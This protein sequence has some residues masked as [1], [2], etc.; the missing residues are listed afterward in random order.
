MGHL[1]YQIGMCDIWPIKVQLVW[2]LTQPA[3]I[4]SGVLWV[5]QLLKSLQTC[6]WARLSMVTLF[7]P[8]MVSFAIKLQISAAKAKTCISI[9]AT[10]NF[11]CCLRYNL[12]GGFAFFRGQ[13]V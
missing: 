3:A 5:P 4:L 9:G 8:P 13:N 12:R 10:N 7:V 1:R 11:Y 2:K 6:L